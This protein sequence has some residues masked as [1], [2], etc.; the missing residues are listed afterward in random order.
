M[1]RAIADKG[2][3]VHMITTSDIKISVLVPEQDGVAVL[4]AVHDAFQLGEAPTKKDV[5]SERPVR[6]ASL[7]ESELVRAR[8]VSRL[9]GMEDI[10]IEQVALDDSQLRYTMADLPDRPGLAAALF[11]RMAS[12]NVNVD[13][14]VQSVGHHD[15]LADLSFT[16]PR[17]HSESVLP[18]TRE[19]CSEFDC[20]CN[21]NPTVAKLTVCGTG[22]RSHTGLAC[23]M[24]KTLADGGIN[25][26]IIC[27][28]ERNISVIVDGKDGQKGHE[29]LLAEFA[30]EMI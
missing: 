28:S 19:L 17:Q 12:K 23:R 3:N 6:S 10:L 18:L 24:F 4:R 7:D 27:T 29:L 20:T 5:R 16:V 9:T 22:L 21:S 2:I 13:M 1:F 26:S 14:I 8:F 15:G 25:V 11:E 30:D